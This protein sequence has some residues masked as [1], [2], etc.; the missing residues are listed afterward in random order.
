[1]SLRAAP[2]SAHR[3]HETDLDVGAPCHLASAHLRFFIYNETK[4]L[5]KEL[6]TYETYGGSPASEGLLQF[7]LWGVKPTDRHDWAGLKVRMAEHGLRN[8]LLV[9]PMPTA[10]TAQ[11]LGNNE[12]V[13][14][15]TRCVENT[16][17]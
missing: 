4:Q 8:S 16:R 12:S 15:F 10:S 2:S 11:I 7:D 14:P 5:A 13:E 1:M 6:G 3:T 17:R 9:A